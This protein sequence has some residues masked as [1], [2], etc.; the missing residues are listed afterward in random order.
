MPQKYS[1]SAAIA[2]VSHVKTF[3][4]GEKLRVELS[5]P[6]LKITASQFPNFPKNG[7]LLSI[8][9]GKHLSKPSMVQPPKLSRDSPRKIAIELSLTVT[10]NVDP[11][12]SYLNIHEAAKGNQYIDRQMLSRLKLLE[13]IEIQTDRV[14]KNT[15]RDE[16]VSY[17]RPLHSVPGLVACIKIQPLPDRPLR[18]SIT[19]QPSAL[20]PACELM[21]DSP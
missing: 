4:V 9:R 7:I 13:K 16:S 15:N 14:S 2:L 18:L 11:D 1:S 12:V 6:N 8:Q 21:P 20:A 3:V 10:L 5:V 19:P 17:E